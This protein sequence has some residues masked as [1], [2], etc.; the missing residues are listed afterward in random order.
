MP[1]LLALLSSVAIAD[2]SDSNQSGF[3]RILKP[4]KKIIKD[5]IRKDRCSDPRPS[6]VFA[7]RVNN[8]SHYDV[9]VVVSG[10]KFYTSEIIDSEA[11][12]LITIDTRDLPLTT[13]EVL[14][15]AFIPV[16]GSGN[17]ISGLKVKNKTVRIGPRVTSCII[18]VKFKIGRLVYGKP[19]EPDPVPSPTFDYAA[20]IRDGNYTCCLEEGKPTYK[21]MYGLARNAPLDAKIL[22]TGFTS[23]QSLFSWIC[24]RPVYFHYW[25][26][27]YAWF[28]YFGQQY[29]VSSLPCDINS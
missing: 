12:R 24:N 16:D 5:L 3:G 19:P 18:G 14:E 15:F 13:G 23:T 2:V 26:S 6:E 7:I 9:E 25:A 4:K 11:N 22:A 20:Y 21:M 8:K 27:N 29:R 17:A 1:C 28:S 10:I